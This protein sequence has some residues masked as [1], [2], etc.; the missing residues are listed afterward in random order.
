[1]V[2]WNLLAPRGTPDQFAPRIRPMLE[3]AHALHQQ[4]RAWFYQALHVDE[5]LD[6]G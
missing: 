1:M 3:Y 4:D 5:V 2:Y 6:D